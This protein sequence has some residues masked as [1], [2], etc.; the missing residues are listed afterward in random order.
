MEKEIINTK[1]KLISTLEKRYGKDFFKDNPLATEKNIDFFVKMVN[2]A[3][4]E[5]LTI[6]EA[7]AMFGYEVIDAIV[8]EYKF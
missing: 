8:D 7:R 1:E 5:G 2:Q 4:K 6:R 3:R